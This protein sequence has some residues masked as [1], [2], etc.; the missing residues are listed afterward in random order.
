M[1]LGIAIARGA[2]DVAH[3]LLSQGV[4]LLNRLF[5]RVLERLGVA[6]TQL[7]LTELSDITRKSRTAAELIFSGQVDPRV[8]PI[9]DPPNF[10][11]ITGAA[12]DRIQ[13]KNVSRLL[14]PD[15]TEID[16]KVMYIEFPEIPDKT[17]LDDYIRRFWEDF[18]AAGHDTI[19]LSYVN[20]PGTIRNFP[21]YAVQR[22]N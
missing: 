10:G 5:D 12:Y 19:G 8:I 2:L 11:S 4:L 14:G 1:N 15:G 17:T 3:G 22:A 13:V 21:V 18:R 9:A 6:L 16:K 7:E 20:L